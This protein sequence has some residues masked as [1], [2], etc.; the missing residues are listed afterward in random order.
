MTREPI[1]PFAGA[2]LRLRAESPT[3]NDI[4]TLI[5]AFMAAEDALAEV[6]RIPLPT[7][8]A[9]DGLTIVAR[10]LFGNSPASLRA[11][12]VRRAKEWLAARR[13]P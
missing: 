4:D 5:E 7:A 3:R 8:V 1:K 10:S 13:A 6:A 11:D 9:Y 2:V 12:T